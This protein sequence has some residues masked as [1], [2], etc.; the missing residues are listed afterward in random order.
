MYIFGVDVSRHNG[1]IDHVKC[2]AAGAKFA[3]SR[4]TV[5]DYYIDTRW[6]EN[7]AGFTAAGAKRLAYLVVVPENSI[8][9][10]ITAEAHVNL[11][12]K[13]VENCELDFPPVLDCELPRIHNPGLNVYLTDLITDICRL[14]LTEFGDYPII[15]TRKTW[16]DPSVNRKSYWYQYPLW[17]A[18]YTTAA[19]PMIPF[20][21]LKWD[22]WQYSSKGPGHVLGAQEEYIDLNYM[23][24]DF[25]QRF[26][27]QDSNPAG[28]MVSVFLDIEDQAYEGELEKIV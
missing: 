8:G 14:L 16:W 21:W 2:A 18:H 25:W 1:Q 11:F 24:P 13:A 20:D 23:Q 5:G 27:G 6:Y 4:C 19:A 12:L 28:N 26:V 10:K 22:L 3:A 17:T 15:Y 9:Q 7:H